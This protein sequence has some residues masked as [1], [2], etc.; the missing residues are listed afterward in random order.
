MFSS[1]LIFIVLKRSNLY[2]NLWFQYTWVYRFKNYMKSWEDQ[3]DKNYWYKY[4]LVKFFKT[5]H[6]S[7]NFLYR[8]DLFK[9]HFRFQ[10]LNHFKS[11]TIYLVHSHLSVLNGLRKD[12]NAQWANA[13]KYN[14]LEFDSSLYAQL[15]ALS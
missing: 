14:F 6:R 11:A 13:N 9:H 5:T 8:S 2:K 12:F 7:I 1:N 3:I 10:Y 15:I 4:Y